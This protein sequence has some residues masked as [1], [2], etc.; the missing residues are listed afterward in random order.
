MSATVDRLNIVVPQSIKGEF[1]MSTW[2]LIDAMNE[3]LMRR[4][5]ERMAADEIAFFSALANIPDFESRYRA[6]LKAFASALCD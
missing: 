6:I 1:Q 4:G 2:M 5:F 3:K